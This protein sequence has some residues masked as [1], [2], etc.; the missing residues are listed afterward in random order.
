[1]SRGSQPLAELALH[2]AVADDALCLSVLAMQVWLDTYATGGVRPAM[3]REVL[4]TYSLAAFEAAIVDRATR[5]VVA[6]HDA[7]MIGFAQ[8]TL[9]A[10]HALAPAGRQAELL[11]L[12]VQEPFTGVGV[13]TRLLARA[14]AAAAKSGATVLWLTPWVYNARALA[15]YGRRGYDDHG[16]TWFRFEGESHENRVFAKSL[17]SAAG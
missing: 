3:A 5:L 10:H 2:D 16:L 4:Q 15:F 12:Y 17:A 6:E 1:M 8:L 13:G 11:R 14:E 9:D 7:H